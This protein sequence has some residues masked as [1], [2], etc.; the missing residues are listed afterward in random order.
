MLVLDRT[1]AGSPFARVSARRISFLF[2]WRCAKQD[3]REVL[4]NY[5]RQWDLLF[6]AN[7]Y[8][9]GKMGGPLLFHA[10]AIVSADLHLSVHVLTLILSQSPQADAYH[11]LV[12]SS[13]LFARL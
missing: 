7:S 3:C 9:V 4:L 5:G 6:D 8:V 2:F 11:F 12:A 1:S 13:L 10:S